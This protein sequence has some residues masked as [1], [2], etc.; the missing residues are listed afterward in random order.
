VIADAAV[1]RSPERHACFLRY[2]Y[3]KD[4]P[5][6]YVDPDGRNP[7]A[8]GGVILEGASFGALEGLV[9]QVLINYFSR[10]PI[11]EQA[12]PAIL[13]GAAI[14]AATAGVGVV[15]K[16]IVDIRRVAQAAELAADAG[17]ISARS[18]VTGE[19]IEKALQATKQSHIFGKRT[20]ELD[21]LVQQFGSR[22]G[23]IREVLAEINKGAQFT[24]VA[25]TK[26][27]TEITLGGQT[28]EVTGSFVDDEFRLGT[29]YILAK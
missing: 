23:V 28:I 14:G 8:V 24:Q 2:A 26:Y 12:G 27:V 13:T 19:T 9:A 7:V 11:G 5:F 4:S 29:F 6:R 1:Q 25:E 17:R 18:R 16:A 10:R 21:A 20:H 15:A 3:G 22:E